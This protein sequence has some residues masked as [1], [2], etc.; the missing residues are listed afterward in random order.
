MLTPPVIHETFTTLPCPDD[1]MTTLALEGCAEQTIVTTDHRID[2]LVRSIF[3]VL[4]TGD[5]R[6][7]LVRSEA[8]WL[9]YRHQSCAAEAS[10][11][12]GGT[13]VGVLDAQC[14]ARRNQSH[15]ADLRELLK[16][17]KAP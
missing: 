2:G 6:K 11:Y 10:K 13:L 4:R 12:A 7:M 15:V 3:G 5:G 8:S 14:Q 17:L 1:A 9:A 16:T